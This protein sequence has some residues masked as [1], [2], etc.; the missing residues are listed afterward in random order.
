[1]QYPRIYAGRQR[2]KARLALLAALIVLPLIGAPF[3]ETKDAAEWTDGQVYAL[4]T[5]SPWAKQTKVELNLEK[6]QA[7][8]APTWKEL[9]IPGS[10]PGRP[11]QPVGSP[12]GGIGGGKPK[13]PRDAQ[14]LIRWSS[15]PVVGQALARY[16]ASRNG[17]ESESKPAEGSESLY[18][19]E[20]LGVPAIA[21]FAGIPVL[22]DELYRSASLTTKSGRVIRPESVYA[23]P[24][25]EVLGISIRFLKDKPLTLDDRYV[26]LA[27]KTSV[28][29]FRKRFELRAMRSRG[30][31]EL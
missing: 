26:E 28:F 24:Q 15:A 29:E 31:L 17:A 4:L 9:K 5:A 13:I 21:A 6:P 27:G 8:G 14:L 23:T 22:Q 1:M 20:V 2:P 3:W 16:K 11:E 7:A 25:G 18:H 12:V 30:K 19:I 10:G